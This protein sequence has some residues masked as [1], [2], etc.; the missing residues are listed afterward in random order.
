[1]IAIDGLLDYDVYRGGPLPVPNRFGYGY[2]LA[3]NGVFIRAQN[4]FVDALQL[5]A[6]AEVRGLPM[7]TPFI[8]PRVGRLPGRLLT[9]IM[10]HAGRFPNQEVV[11]QVVVENG[12]FKVHVVAFGDKTSAEFVDV[13]TSDKIL[14]EAHSHNTMTAFFSATDNAYEQYFRWYA[15]LGRVTAE[16]PQAA[17]RLGVYGYHFPTRLDSLF[18]INGDEDIED[19]VVRDDSMGRMMGRARRQV[20]YKRSDDDTD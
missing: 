5:V 15:V 14:F 2:L 4:N 18:V 10:T 12:R 7:L 17:L 11:Y 3:G 16:R 19:V 13:A 20:G 9:A 6:P 8:R 1:M